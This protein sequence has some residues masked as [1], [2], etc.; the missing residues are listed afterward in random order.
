MHSIALLAFSALVVALAA[1]G[2]SPQLGADTAGEKGNLRF[3]YSSCLFGC[4]LD[5][6]A[7][8][9]S[10]VSITTK[11]GDPDVPLVARLA[12]DPVG[13][14][15]SQLES[16]SCASSSG[17]GSRSRSIDA[18]KLCD[19]AETKSCTLA[20]DIDTRTAGEAKLEIVDPAGAVV[21][22]VTVHVRP[23]ARIELDVHDRKADAQGI[24]EV[25]WGAKLKVGSKV[26]DADGVGMIF[27]KH[28]VTQAYADANIV[29]PDSSVLVGSTD[30]EDAVAKR[31]GE[32]SLTVRAV[33]A[34]STVRFRVTK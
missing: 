14:I 7:L 33:G 8:Q 29:G 21:D 30:V 17:N 12:G 34:E 9:G 22:R 32:T 2:C 13:S 23:A 16:C 27:A 6:K 31:A 3:E 5:Q 25:G 18:S 19:K 10:Q 28:G 4:S 1:A 15:A 20:V 11:G 24:Y 26:L